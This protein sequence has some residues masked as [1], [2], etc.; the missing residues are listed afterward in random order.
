MATTWETENGTVVSLCRTDARLAAIGPFESEKA[1]TNVRGIG[2]QMIDRVVGMLGL[3]LAGVFYAIAL[4]H[5]GLILLG[6]RMTQEEQKPFDKGTLR[7]PVDLPTVTVIIPARDEEVVIEGAIRCA[8]G[9]DYP[10][11]LLQ[12]V[13]VEDGSKD[14]TPTIGK[15]LAAKLPHVTCLSGGDSK[16]KPAALN[17]ALRIAT[18]DVIAVFDSDTRYDAD[19]LLR[20]AKFF[21]D[22]PDVDVAQAIPRVVDGDRNLITRMNGYEMRFWYQG[23]H[24]A[25]DRFNLFVHL[26]GTGMFLRRCVLEEVGAWDEECLTEDLEY[27]LR[28]MLLKRKVALFPGEVRIQ[29]TYTVSHLIRQRRRWWRGALQVLWKSLR[30]RPPRGLPLRL[31]VDR[32]LYLTSPLV[33]LISSLAFFGS[34]AI[35]TAGLEAVESIAIWVY[36]ILSTNLILVPLVVTESVTR[37]SGRLLLVIPGLYWYW[38]L[39]IVAL[40]S[41]AVDIVL[42]RKP[43]WTPTPK[44]KLD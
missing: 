14:E 4:Y 43:A 39:Q 37:R 18:G 31:R 36:G 44:R 38:V 9:L 42:G 29:P 23:L 7:N 35:L 41:V 34:L 20:A 1:L 40:L 5:V 27:S 22:R 12:I 32:T 30:T 15:R 8:D 33:F 25:K 3:L 2:A 10:R 6:L 13:V 19:L 17:R 11:E 16:G 21:H 26:A 24:A 28:L